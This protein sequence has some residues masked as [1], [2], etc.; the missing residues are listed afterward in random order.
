[1]FMNLRAVYTMRGDY[2]R[3]FVVFDRLL[4]LWP[5][6]VDELRDRGFLFARLG[7]PDAALADLA[8]YLERSPNAPDAA[9]V[10]AWLERIEET[11]RL[12]PSR[13]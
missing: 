3:L 4:D 13:S 6:S 7:A 9:D 5:N 11:A 12:A 8:P 2:A 1:M 10:R